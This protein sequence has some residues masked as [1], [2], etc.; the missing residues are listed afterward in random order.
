[1]VGLIIGIIIF[2]ATPFGVYYLGWV[3]FDDN[4]GLDIFLAIAVGVIGGLVGL[5]LIVNQS[6]KIAEYRKNTKGMSKEQKKEYRKMKRLEAK[7]AA[8]EDKN[9]P[10]CANCYYY[11]SGRCKLHTHSKWVS[12]ADDTDGYYKDVGLRVRGTSSCGSFIHK[13]SDSAKSISNREKGRPDD[14]KW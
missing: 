5:F 7:Q 3:A 6:M 13:Y 8:E 12:N 10:V 1:M 2:L 4:T 11:E 9:K 14:F